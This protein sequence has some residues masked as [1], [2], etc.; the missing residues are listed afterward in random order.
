LVDSLPV[1]LTSLQAVRSDERNGDSV[2]ERGF[3]VLAAFG[4]EGRGLGLGELARRT[5]LPKATT[6]RLATQLVGLGALERAGD[7]YRLGLALFELGSTVW[8]QRRL[9]DAALPY[10]ADLY[11]ATHQLVHLGVPD[12]LD[13][14]YVEKILGRRSAVAPTQVGTRRPLYCTALGKAILAFSESELVETVIEGGLARRTSYTITSR[15]RLLEELAAVQAKGVAYDRQEYALGT[16][17]VAAP[18]LNR[19]RIAEGA[20]SV[21]GRTGQFIPERAA[22]AVQTAALSLSRALDG[23]PWPA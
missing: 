1:A 5:Q 23:T 9:R 16:I 6:F 12:G 15:T 2:L 21:T 20:L 7:G 11:E 13:V 19:A 22:A 4:P 3:R 18:L 17:C 8:R 14:L 10:M